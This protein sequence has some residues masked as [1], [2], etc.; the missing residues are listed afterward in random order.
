MTGVM[1]ARRH[2]IGQQRAIDRK[3][4]HRQHADVADEALMTSL[5]AVFD[6]S[7]RYELAFWDMAF[8]GPG[9]QAG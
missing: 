8:A 3:E 9:G 4:L 5:A 1:H 7:T 6:R 2:L